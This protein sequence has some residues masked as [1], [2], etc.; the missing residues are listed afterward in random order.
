MT[1]G[2]PPRG[3]KVSTTADTPEFDGPRHHDEDGLGR[4]HG[5]DAVARGI[6]P[7]V[8]DGVGVVAGAPAR[9]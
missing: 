7:G 2:R 5:V 3:P 1:A 6:G 8:D 4:G 9:G